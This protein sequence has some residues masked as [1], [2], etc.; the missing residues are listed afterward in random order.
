MAISLLNYGWRPLLLL[1][2]AAG[3]RQEI[4]KMTRMLKIGFIS[5]VQL[6]WIGHLLSSGLRGQCQR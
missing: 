2:V 5:V 6:K 3:L 4:G 1:K